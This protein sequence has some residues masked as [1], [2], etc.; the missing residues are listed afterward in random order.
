MLKDEGIKVNHKLP[1]Y[2]NYNEYFNATYTYVNESYMRIHVR[3]DIIPNIFLVKLRISNATMLAS[4]YYSGTLRNSSKQTVY[5]FIF[6]K[7]TTYTCLVQNYLHI[8]VAQRKI[9]LINSVMVIM[10]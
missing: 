9:Y 1:N 6:K 10:R 3:V 8:N 2:Y 7:Y 5:L 4:L